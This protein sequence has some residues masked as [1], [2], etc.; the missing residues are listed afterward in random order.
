MDADRTDQTRPP[1]RRALLARLR[2]LKRGSLVAA[3]VGF[4]ALV[5]L[6]AS[7]ETRGGASAT[8]RAHAG[9]AAQPAASAEDGSGTDWGA[10]QVYPAPVTQAPAATSGAS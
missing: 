1:D 7:A 10:T 3:L 2:L 6:A 4:A 5:G 8:T 9:E